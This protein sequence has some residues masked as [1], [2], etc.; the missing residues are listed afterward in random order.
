MDYG[1]TKN[2]SIVLTELKNSLIL[3]RGGTFLMG[4][5]NGY[6]DKNPVHSVTLSSFLISKYEVTQKEYHIII[7][8]NPSATDRGIGD[9]YPINEV[10]WHDAV[11][12]CNALSRKEGL[13][14]AYSG[15][16]DNISCNFNANGYRLPT[17]AEWEYAAR[18]QRLGFPY[19]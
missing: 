16:G 11:E 19:C 10:S 14:P 2:I 4:S 18:G 15:N 8:S 9:N 7:G 17:E 12:Y 13:T 6:S 1:K 3:I 5:T